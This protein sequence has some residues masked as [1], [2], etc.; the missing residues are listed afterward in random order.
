C[1]VLGLLSMAFTTFL[2][3][4]SIVF[5]DDFDQGAI[6][7][8]TFS[9]VTSNHTIVA[10]FSG[11]STSTI[12][13]N[14]VQTDCNAAGDTRNKVFFSVT[15]GATPTA[16]KGAIVNKGGGNW[17]LRHIGTPS[18]STTN[19]TIS[20]GGDSETVSVTA[21]D[22][23]GGTPSVTI[24]VT[25]VVTDCNASGKARNVIFFTVDGSTATPTVNKGTV[26]ADGANW[27]VREVN[28]AFGSTTNYTISV[29]GVSKT[30]SV[31]AVSS[32]P[33]FSEG[34]STDATPMVFPNPA[35]DVVNVAATEGSVVNIY[36]MQ[37]QRVYNNSN[38][39][40]LLKISIS[41]LG[42]QG[43]YLINVNGLTSQVV[44]K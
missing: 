30:E 20:A 21:A 33:K 1:L 44:I 34:L 14:D 26:I 42:G 16:N 32:C 5:K 12:T 13:I 8:Y 28:V 19:Y 22:C 10:N 7:T 35:T 41:E 2:L 17:L 11:G 24:T 18:G 23:G 36:N 37:G 27:K 39:N 25:N 40:G 43:M 4:F 31:T 15:G 6:G 29:A 3:V 38:A 9:N